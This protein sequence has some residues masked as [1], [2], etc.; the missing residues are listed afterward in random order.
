MQEASGGANGALL[1]TPD[2]TG[3][4]PM[5]ATAGKVA[6]VNT[7][8]AL[9]GSG[10]PFGASVSTLLVMERLQIASKAAGRAPAPSATT[11]DVRKGGGCV[12]TNDNAADF[13]VQTPS[14]RN[15]S[16][17]IN[18]CRSDGGLDDQ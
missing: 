7:T 12:D 11:S 3:T 1:P 15:S 13:F 18:S 14:P 17:P 10:C 2:V 9:T 6:L 8:T 16:S 4:I 5:A